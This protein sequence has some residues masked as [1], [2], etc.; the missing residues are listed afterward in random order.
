MLIVLLLN[1]SIILLILDARLTV[2]VF[3]LALLLDTSLM[4]LI[5]VIEVVLL[6]N[7]R[8]RLVA[9]NG[10]IL[11]FLKFMLSDELFLIVFQFLFVL[12]GR[13]LSLQLLCGI[14]LLSL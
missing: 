3:E 8:L 2:L 14:L 1:C 12:K 9:L 11:I 4:L 13:I 10:L 6:L 7:F 5:R